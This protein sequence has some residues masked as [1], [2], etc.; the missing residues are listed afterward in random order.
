MTSNLINCI[1]LLFSNLCCLKYL[2]IKMTSAMFGEN[3]P[4][5]GIEKSLQ[6]NTATV[7]PLFNKQPFLF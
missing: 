1:L 6:K 3:C 2:K 7:A 4:N 5:Q